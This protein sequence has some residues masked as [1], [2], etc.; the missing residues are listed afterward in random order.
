MDHAPN[1]FRAL[2]AEWVVL[3]EN[4]RARA[5]LAAWATREPVL[6]G[7]GSPAEV[8]VFCNARR[9]VGS[10]NDVLGALLRVAGSDPLG[11][12]AVLQAVLP[13]LA[14]L[15]R[16]ARAAT[17]S[18]PGDSELWDQEVVALAWEQITALAD[19]PPRWP[20]MAIVNLTW[21][22]LRTAIDRHRRNLWCC[23]TV[24]DE[25]VHGDVRSTA[26]QLADV[27]VEAV[28]RGTISRDAAAVVLRTRVLGFSPAETARATGRSPAWVYK[29]RERAERSLA[30][31]GE[32]LRFAS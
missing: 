17:V 6:R 8:V 22:R 7:F 1:L 27:L 4:N 14:G 11:A 15:A 18:E 31:V 21:T 5:R 23:A 20:A 28:R 29:Q 32:W 2:E 26:D 30:T 24:P 19:S 13:A 9:D 12:R 10:A 16:R 25:P 3:G